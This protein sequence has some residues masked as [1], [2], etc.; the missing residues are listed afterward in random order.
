MNVAAENERPEP[1][2]DVKTLAEYLG[3]TAFYVCSNADALGARRLPSKPRKRPDGTLTTP[4]PRLRFSLEEVEKRLASCSEGRGSTSPEPAPRA[5][6]APRG[7]RG[8]G[9]SVD[10]LPIR[11]R[12]HG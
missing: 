11:G 7:R 5:A 4:K 3:V 2:V 10:L 6:S 8:M 12:I 9:T 1:L